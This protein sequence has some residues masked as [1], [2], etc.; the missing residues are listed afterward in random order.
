MS[1]GQALRQVARWRALTLTP[2]QLL[3]LVLAELTSLLSLIH[4]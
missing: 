4:I 1:E 2:A 3:P